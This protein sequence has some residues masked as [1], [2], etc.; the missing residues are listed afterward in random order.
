MQNDQYAFTASAKLACTLR[1][2]HLLLDQSI[3]TKR[4]CDF[5][6]NHDVQVQRNTSMADILTLRR[7]HPAQPRSIRNVTRDVKVNS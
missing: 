7:P 5:S 3:Q 2:T 4:A 6:D 1:N